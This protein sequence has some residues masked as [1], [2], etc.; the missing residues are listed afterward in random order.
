M[1]FMA[2]SKARTKTSSLDRKGGIDQ[3]GERKKEI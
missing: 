2:N 3:E 1:T